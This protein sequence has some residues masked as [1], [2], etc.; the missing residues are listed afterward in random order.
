LKHFNSGIG[1]FHEANKD[2]FVSFEDF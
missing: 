1:T 2:M